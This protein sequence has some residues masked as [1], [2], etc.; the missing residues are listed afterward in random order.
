MQLMALETCGRLGSFARKLD[1]VDVSLCARLN[2]FSR[3]PLVRDLFR[4]ISRVGDGVLWYCMMAVLP[5]IGGYSG[6]VA[7]LHMAG[8]ALAGLAIYR[9]T[10]LLSGRERPYVQHGDQVACVMPPLDRYSF[11][12]GHT[13]HAVSFTMVLYGYFPQMIWVLMPLTAL[14][15][16]SRMILGLHYPSDVLAGAAIG[17]ALAL[18]SFRLPLPAA[19]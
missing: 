2:R 5:V 7:T 19:S 1:N 12:S 3:T 15:A 11:P 8:T 10:K 16:L 13:L 17:A 6:L 9:I 4:I 14:I 18:V